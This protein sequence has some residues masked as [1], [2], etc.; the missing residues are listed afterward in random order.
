MGES[1]PRPDTGHQLDCQCESCYCPIHNFSLRRPTR[2]SHKWSYQICPLC[3][4][5]SETL[6]ARSDLIGEYDEEK[7]LISEVELAEY[8]PTAGSILWVLGSQE[9]SDWY[10]SGRFHA[11]RENKTSSKDEILKDINKMFSGVGGK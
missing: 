1:F 7:F 5:D 9:F 6:A 2:P 10:N 3:I 8:G 4:K 11:Y